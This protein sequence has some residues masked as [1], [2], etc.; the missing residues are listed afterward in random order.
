[1]ELVE[2]VLTA[3]ADGAAVKSALN[4]AAENAHARPEVIEVLQ[5]LPDRRYT[6]VLDLGRELTGLPFDADAITAATRA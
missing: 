6:S 4:E 2:H 1:M 5:Q 3:F